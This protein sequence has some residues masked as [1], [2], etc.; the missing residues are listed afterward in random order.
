MKKKNG[1]K[2]K[3]EPRFEF[4]HDLFTMFMGY[5]KFV[6]A[7]CFVGIKNRCWGIIGSKNS[8]ILGRYFVAFLWK[9]KDVFVPYIWLWIWIVLDGWYT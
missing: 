6:W 8:Y 7:M 4:N 2:S 9:W 5:G 3:K 1:N